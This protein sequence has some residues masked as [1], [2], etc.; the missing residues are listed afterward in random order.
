MELSKRKHPVTFR[1]ALALFSIWMTVLSIHSPKASLLDVRKSKQLLGL[2]MG[3]P[4]GPELS[5]VAN[6]VK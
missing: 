4:T 5:Q 3:S 2:R 6:W 1:Q